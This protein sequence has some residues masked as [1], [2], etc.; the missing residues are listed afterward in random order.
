MSLQAK[1]GDRIGYPSVTD[2]VSYEL[3]GEVVVPSSD[4]SAPV[5]ALFPTAEVGDTV[6]VRARGIDAQGDPG[7]WSP[8]TDVLIIGLDAP[9]DPFIV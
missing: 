8:Q 6:L 1:L 7:E 2:A 3:E 4:P 5:S 9:G